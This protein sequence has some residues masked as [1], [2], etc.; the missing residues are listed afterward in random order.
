MTSSL[1][2]GPPPELDTTI[3][4]IRERFDTDSIGRAAL[5]S[6]DARTVPMLPD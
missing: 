1:D 5:L 6:S 4:Q 3:N 2:G